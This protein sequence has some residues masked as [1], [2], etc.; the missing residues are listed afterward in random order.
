MR[1]CILGACPALPA[2]LRRHI[3]ALLKALLDVK[4]CFIAVMDSFRSH[5]ETDVEGVRMYKSHL[6]YY[7]PEEAQYMLRKEGGV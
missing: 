6:T 7:C 4:R 3:T 5:K 2:Q 1:T